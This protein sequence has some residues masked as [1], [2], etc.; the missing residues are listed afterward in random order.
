MSEESTE[1]RDAVRAAL[2]ELITFG[3]LIQSKLPNGKLAYKLVEP[4]PEKPSDGKTHRRKVRRII[5]TDSYK[6]IKNITNTGEA[7]SPFEWG[8]CLEKLRKDEK[9]HIKIIAAF[10]KIKNMRFS[11][12]AQVQTAIRRHAKAAKEL[13]PFEDEKLI[14]TMRKLNYEWP[15]FTLETVAKELTK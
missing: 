14:E 4:E 13:M 7:S 2:K 11:S 5:N 6:E 1:G 3:Y 10:F 8:A 12:D 9:R 15:K